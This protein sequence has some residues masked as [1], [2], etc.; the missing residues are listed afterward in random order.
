MGGT[1]AGGSSAPSDSGVGGETGAAGTAAAGDSGGTAG[2]GGAAGSDANNDCLDDISDYSA[3]G[4]FSFE[5]M[6]SDQVN[7]WI[8]DVP[9]GCKVP[10]VHFANGTGATCATYMPAIAHLASHGFLVTCYESPQTGEGTQCVTA[11]ETAL[12]EHP[13]IADTKVGSAGHS[14][15]G[16]SAIS[17]VYHAEQKWGDALQI[18][19][20]GAEPDRAGAAIAWTDHFGGVSSPIFMFS[21]SEDFLVSENAARSSYEALNPG[22]ESYWYEGVGATH[23]PVPVSFIQDSSVAWF[24]WKLL[25]DEAACEYFKGMPDSNLWDLQSERNPTGC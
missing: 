22:A 12:A 4:P 1:S 2:A 25:G 16:S 11:I 10:I 24:R 7:L 3:E 9:A 8:P 21:G 23:V 6:R 15:G 5:S 17:C 20:Y 14:T 19:G 18:V 13:D